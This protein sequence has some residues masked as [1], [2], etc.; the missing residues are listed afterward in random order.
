MYNLIEVQLDASTTWIK[1]LAHGEGWDVSSEVYQLTTKPK[2]WTQMS[3]MEI[4]QRPSVW[5]VWKIQR[6]IVKYREQCCH[7]KSN[8]ATEI[9][10]TLWYCQVFY[11]CNANM[12]KI[13]TDDLYTRRNKRTCIYND[14][15]I[16]WQRHSP[17]L[18]DINYNA[19]EFP[20][21]L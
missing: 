13:I 16:I 17:L 19:L 2:D 12:A 11:N 9:D 7:I 8:L 1:C 6:I 20:I 4:L 14:P 10:M 15:V 3:Y 5:L 18:G 21:C